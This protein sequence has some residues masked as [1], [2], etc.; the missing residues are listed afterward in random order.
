MLN[1]QRQIGF[2]I[3]ELLVVIVVIAILAAI[4][5]VGYNGI[6]TRSANTKTVSAVATYIKALRLYQT[7]EGRYP[8]HTNYPCLGTSTTMCGA[9]PSGACWGLGYVS[10]STAF[11][12]DIK[13]YLG[14]P[15]ELSDQRISCTA[16][17]TVQGGFY[18]SSTDG[19]TAAI[20]YFLKGNVDCGGPGGVNTSRVFSQ[21][22][23]WC[24]IAI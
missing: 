10:G 6:Q 22:A 18:Q 2:T 19:A 24:G 8:I 14:A 15:P 7:Q 5:V 16:T 23:T 11:A 3:V 21:D 20:Y 12:N 17:A 4:T 1:Q 13:A 9:S